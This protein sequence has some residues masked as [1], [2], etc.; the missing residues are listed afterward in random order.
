MM[1]GHV[2]SA[3]GS[4]LVRSIIDVAVGAPERLIFEAPPVIEAPL[5]Q[6]PVARRPVV[7]PGVAI[8]SYAACPPLTSHERAEVRRLQDNAKHALA[9]ERNRILGE[10]AEKLAKQRGITIDAARRIVD[11]QCRG[12]LSSEHV[13]EF[14]DPDI[15]RPTTV[16]DLLDDPTKYDGETLAD[17]NE[18]IAYGP[19]KAKVMIDGEGAPWIHS[20]A[21]G[22]TIYHLR[23]SAAAVRERIERATGDVV[24]VFIGLVLRA[25]LDRLERDDLIEIVAERARRKVTQIRAAVEEALK[26][27]ARRRKEE[28]RE[29]RRS[30]AQRSPPDPAATV[31]GSAAD[32]GDGEDQRRDRRRAPRTAAA[33][34]PRGS[35]RQDALAVDPRDSRLRRRPR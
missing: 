9:D 8:D 4:Y 22:R 2:L 25:K 7:H 28:A 1:H 16:G 14:D 35:R 33:A 17:P 15:A 20:F 3:A 5:A 6:D 21:H 19:N 27:Q 29:R 26:D 31:A 10:R 30:R 12:I 24:A 34:R 23:Y 13:L 11:D 32:G 18:G